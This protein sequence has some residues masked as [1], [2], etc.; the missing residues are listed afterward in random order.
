[1][2]HLLPDARIET[3]LEGM[4]AV[5]RDAGR[6]ARMAEEGPRRAQAYDW[7]RV[8]RQYLDLLI[9]IAQRAEGRQ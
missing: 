3:L 8:T 2:A 7:H 5:L 4:H 1:V 6:R 9:P